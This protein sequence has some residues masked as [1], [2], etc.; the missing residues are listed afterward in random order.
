MK[1]AA[2]IGI[3]VLAAASFFAINSNLKDKNT[4]EPFVAEAQEETE[5]E[6]A[7]A[8]KIDDPDI[9]EIRADLNLQPGSRIAVVSK[10]TQGE[11][12]NLVL[13]GMQT[14]IDH[15]ND[16]Y[17]FEKENKITFTFEGSE[18]EQDIENQINTMDA[19]IAENPDV[20][21][22]SAGDMQACQAQLEAATENGIPVVV[23]D[24]NVNDTTLVSAYRGTDNLEVGRIAAEKLS[25]AIG[26]SGQIAIFSVNEKT[27]SIQER[28]QGF[29]NFY[30]EY[31]NVEIVE[32]IYEN[33]EEDVVE[34]M[35]E[36][37]VSYPDLK[38]V[39]CTNATI[40]E[41]YLSIQ[42]EEGHDV[43]MVGVDG[44]KA[45]LQAIKDG[46]EIGVV[47]QHAFAIGYQTMA[48]ALECST[49]ESIDQVEKRKILQPK[50]IDS[51]NME[52]PENAPYMY[53]IQ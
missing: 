28:I 19:V 29:K 27:T 10:S 36:V 11:F 40:A 7:Q 44:T 17:G 5:V 47:S 25:E 39:F 38:G 13:Q 52:L 46:K 3:F 22:I 42:Q 32:N 41:K 51:G 45:Q 18:N 48:A 20:L 12:W 53:N 37:L 31:E 30:T 33:S 21:C 4:L 24:S 1:K 9:P 43:K 16:V 2:F 14:A 35:K 23:F 15:V 50:W 49:P 26:E 6:D 8:Q 34:V